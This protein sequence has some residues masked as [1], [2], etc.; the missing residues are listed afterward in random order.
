MLHSHNHLYIHRYVQKHSQHNK[1]ERTQFF[2]KIYLSHFI[3]K[4]YERVIVWEVSWRLNKN[5]NIFI[6]LALLDIAAFLARS[7]WLL[8]RGPGDPASAGSDSHSSNWLQTLFSNISELPVAPGFITIRR[9]PASCEHYICTQFNPSTVKLSPD[10][11]DQ[12]HVSFT[13][14]HFSFDN[15]AGVNM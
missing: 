1:D 4:G 10:I 6:T 2:R 11:F 7:A 13:Q 15:L 14:V 12:M 3:R 5:Y 9:S 8:N